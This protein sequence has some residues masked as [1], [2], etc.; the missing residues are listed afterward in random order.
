MIDPEYR[1]VTTEEMWGHA[2]KMWQQLASATTVDKTQRKVLEA[3][4][5]RAVFRV[6]RRYFAE[7]HITQGKTV[8]E[9]D[10]LMEAVRIY[11]GMG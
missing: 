5:G 1:K 2:Q 8:W 6:T 10:E 9:G 3:G 11:N 7:P 4:V